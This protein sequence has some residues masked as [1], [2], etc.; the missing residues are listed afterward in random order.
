V[1]GGDAFWF[2]YA[3][4][5]AAGAAMTGYREA[6]RDEPILRTVLSIAAAYAV[7]AAL[8]VWL[9]GWPSEYDIRVAPEPSSTDAPDLHGRKGTAPE[10]A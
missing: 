9:W 2:V 8:C 1:T 3:I 10:P 4:G 5:V 6:E 7:G